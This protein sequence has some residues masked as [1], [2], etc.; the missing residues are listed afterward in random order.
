MTLT[1]FGMSFVC[2]TSE[3][4]GGDDVALFRLRQLDEDTLVAAVS[5]LRALALLYLVNA[6]VDVVALDIELRQ[7]LEYVELALEATGRPPLVLAGETGRL[8]FGSTPPVKLVDDPG[9]PQPLLPL[10]E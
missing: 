2:D 3:D 6:D 8:P 5:T 4:S 9:I 1:F 7:L 10:V